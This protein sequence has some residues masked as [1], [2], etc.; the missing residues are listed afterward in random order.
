MCIVVAK[1]DSSVEVLR[2]W[3]KRGAIDNKWGELCMDG[4]QSLVNAIYCT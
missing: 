1:D 3:E 4:P 2:D